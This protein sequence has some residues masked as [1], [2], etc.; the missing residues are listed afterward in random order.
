[1]NFNNILK[2]IL[3]INNQNTIH[4][5]ITLNK[6]SR[7]L[8]IYTVSCIYFICRLTKIMELDR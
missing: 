7:S 6:Y 3:M 1:M 5:I 8:H 4:K 2:I